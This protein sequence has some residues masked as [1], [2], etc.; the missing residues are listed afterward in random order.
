MKMSQVHVTYKGTCTYC[1]SRLKKCKDCKD[2]FCATRKDN[3]YCSSKC[4]T[5]RFRKLANG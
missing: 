2:W 4:R 5:R 1:G 3:I